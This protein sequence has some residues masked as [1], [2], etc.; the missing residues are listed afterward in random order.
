MAR[1]EGRWSDTWEDLH[2]ETWIIEHQIKTDDVIEMTEM[3]YVVSLIITLAVLASALPNI[4]SMIIITIKQLEDIGSVR[5][6]KIS[7]P[8]MM[9]K[10]DQQKGVSR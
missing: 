9:K 10:K 5:S 3:E 6:R 2:D 1:R 7:I 4:I 8:H